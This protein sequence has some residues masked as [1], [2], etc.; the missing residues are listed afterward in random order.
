[1]GGIYSSKDLGSSWSCGRTGLGNAQVNS[2]LINGSNIFVGTEGGI[3]LS[4]DNGSNWSARNTGLTN[5]SIHSFAAKGDTIFAGTWT[6]IH[7]STN[8]GASWRLLN[9]INYPVGGIV[10]SGSDIFA[11]TINGG[12]VFFSTDWG[13]TWTQRN[14]GLTNLFVYKLAKKG[15]TASDL[16]MSNFT[17]AA[18]PSFPSKYNKA[19]P[20]KRRF[21]VFSSASQKPNRVESYRRLHDL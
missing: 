18:G 7:I 6:G 20:S 12:G 5:Y 21:S 8:S 3:Y 19:S 15:A 2:I 9:G 4:T 16:S 13:E 11:G 17:A 10:I 14:T 1:M